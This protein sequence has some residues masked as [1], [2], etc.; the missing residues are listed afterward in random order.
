MYESRITRWFERFRSM[1]KHDWVPR[2]LSPEEVVAECPIRATTTLG[3]PWRHL[4]L[5]APV[6]HPGVFPNGAAPLE[7]L[8]GTDRNT[9]QSVIAGPSADG[10]PY[11]I[12]LSP[13]ASELV[14]GSIVDDDVAK[15]GAHTG[16]VTRCGG[17]GIHALLAVLPM[18]E[19]P[20]RF[21]IGELLREHG[22][23]PTDLCV[24]VT[25]V[26]PLSEQSPERV[27]SAWD[28]VFVRSARV[29]RMTELNA[30]TL[31]LEHEN[32]VLQDVYEDAFWRTCDALA[33]RALGSPA[34]H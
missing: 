33:D 31:I 5:G 2:L 23:A 10:M 9:I 8:L 16:M 19:V 4:T 32:R 28:A 27:R 15:R 25:P 1:S 12:V 14:I 26:P 30:P 18:P 6:V 7:N 34:I 20:K 22:R 24:V 3:D 13:G 17:A 21:S 11:R 29:T